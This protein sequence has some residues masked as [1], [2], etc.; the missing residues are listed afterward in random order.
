MA[1]PITLLPFKTLTQYVIGLE[2]VGIFV[3]NL[4]R[5]ETFPER[6]AIYFVD[7]LVPCATRH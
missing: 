3:L 7:Q 4:M 2:R 5:T 1:S 6:C